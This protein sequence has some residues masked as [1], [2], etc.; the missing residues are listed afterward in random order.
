LIFKWIALRLR[1]LHGFA[2]QLPFAI[3]IGSLQ[4]NSELP[5]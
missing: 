3:L 2:R 1:V 5:F 4:D